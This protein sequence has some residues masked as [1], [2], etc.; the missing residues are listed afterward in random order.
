MHDRPARKPVLA[1]ACLVALLVVLAA[2]FTD[3]NGDIDELALYNPSYMLA[4]Y[5]NLTEPA[6]GNFDVPMIVQPPVHAG[7][8]GIFTRLG[9]TWYYAEATPTVIL[10]LVAILAIVRSCFPEPVKLG[11]LF[12]IGLLMLPGE[13][14]AVLFGTR[15]EGE[16]QAAW[17]AGLVLLESGRLDNW[18]RKRLFAGAFLLT[19]ASGLHYYAAPAFTGVIVYVIWAICSLGWKNAKAPLLA[20]CAG[21]CLFGVPYLAFYLLPYSRLVRE[22]IGGSDAGEGIATAMREHLAMY[23]ALAANAGLPAL[24]REPLRLGIPLLVF[25][26]ALLAIFPSTRGIALAALPIQLFIYFTSH[27]QFSYLIHEIALLSA[28][29]CIAGLV[30]LSWLLSRIRAPAIQRSGLAVMATLLGVYLLSGNPVPRGVAISTQPRIHEADV[31]RA[32]MREILGPQA[33]VV[34]RLGAWYSSGAQHW[35]SL[36]QD[37]LLDTG[38]FDVARYF[39]NF[40]AAAEYPH[41]SDDTQNEEHATISSW[42]ADG[43]LKLR[44]F[45]FAET[46]GELHLLLFSSQLVTQVQGYA[47][48]DHQLYQF[49]EAPSGDYSVISAECP[50][51][52][53]LS[54][55]VVLVGSPSLFSTMLRLPKHAASPPGVLVTVL[56]PRHSPEPAGWIRQSCRSIAEISGWLRIADRTALVDRLR[57][58]DQP[59]H[60]YRKVENVPGY[61]G[62]GV[63]PAATPPGNSVVLGRVLDLPHIQ[64]GDP[65]AR[66]ERTPQ[67]RIMTGPRLGTYAA[68]IP[69][70]QGAAIDT[71]NW[72]KIRLRVTVGRIGILAWNPKLGA[73]KRTPF[74][75]LKNVE[76]LD[77]V[78][79]MPSLRDTAYITIVNDS[80]DSPSQV[81]L[82][83]AAVLVSPETW[84]R[85]RAVLSNL[86]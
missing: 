7:L 75:V 35:H 63:P 3:R 34:S 47:T 40:D 84:E 46:N 30:A 23:R 16:V 50:A 58:E 22:A 57:R 12:S 69:V 56:T 62:V 51:E 68:I 71:P 74:S 86:R 70:V 1:F 76:P 83:E 26:T 31:A 59:I 10:F 61:T 5:G 25:S 52:P 73:L 48:R 9:F 81:E 80:D 32:A 43:T 19:W 28:A 60:F 11:L 44:G 78:L 33:R 53:V 82:L 21:G 8:I 72:V 77:V 45:Y 85:N 14:L 36:R 41:L 6:F 20:L 29:I 79:S 39:A 42:F 13:G 67:L 38:S 4:H 49:R 55:R 37:L 15:P 2:Y 18:N 65:S 17:L 54:G 64:I 27:K 66:I 24:I